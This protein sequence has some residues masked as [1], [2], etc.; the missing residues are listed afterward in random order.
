[1]AVEPLVKSKLSTGQHIRNTS[2]KVTHPARSV[3]PELALTPTT[4]E[5]GYQLL[6]RS[7]WVGAGH[8]QHD[9]PDNYK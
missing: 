3:K 1:M 7:E 8:T 5:C 6:E 2:A 9:E 4:Y